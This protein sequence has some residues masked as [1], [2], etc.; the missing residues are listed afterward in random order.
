MIHIPSALV[1]DKE[2]LN[3]STYY[4]LGIVFVMLSVLVSVMFH[5]SEVLLL[6]HSLTFA[7]MSPTTQMNMI[8]SLS[9]ILDASWGTRENV[10]AQNDAF[11]VVFVSYVCVVLPWS[12][13]PSS[14]SSTNFDIEVNP[15][16]LGFQK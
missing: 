9:N 5:P 4:V 14:I 12:L 8:Y 13:H 1:S 2:V 15:R 6:I 7:A 3:F 16:T 10:R 11:C